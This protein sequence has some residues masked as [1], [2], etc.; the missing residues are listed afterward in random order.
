MW[1]TC[2]MKKARQ[3]VEYTERRENMYQEESAAMRGIYRKAR[4]RVSGRKG[5]KCGICCKR[6]KTCIS[7]RAREVW[8]MQK[9][10]E[11]KYQ[12]ESVEHSASAGKLGANN[13]RA[14]IVYCSK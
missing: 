11:K 8:N 14:R 9:R 4:K 10:G 5:G 12:Q 1:E 2:M 3:S 6:G 7:K 13:R